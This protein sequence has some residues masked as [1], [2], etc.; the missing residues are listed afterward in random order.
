MRGWFH[1]SREDIWRQLSAD[2]E[3]RYVDGGVWRGDKVE[4]THGDWVVTLD[5]YSVH[6]QHVH[7]TYTRI[8]A[9]Y[10]NPDGFRF[11]IYRR[12]LF[13]DIAT[14][15]GMQDITIHDEAF[16]R[17]F[18]V[19]GTNEAKVLELLGESKVRTLIAAQPKVYLTV[20]DD[21]GWF[22]SRY[23]DGVD[24]LYFQ[25]EGVIKDVDRLKQLFEL[26]AVTLDRLCE[27]GSAYR[28]TV[29]VQPR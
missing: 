23:P 20:K 18:I 16:D 25:T 5:T 17:D 14:W 2:I 6:T 7:I 8:R 4:A 1:P 9:P 19:K 27:I 13:S 3:A 10:V 28:S 24:A 29:P 11:T 22:K 21:E 12:T 26:F 15:F